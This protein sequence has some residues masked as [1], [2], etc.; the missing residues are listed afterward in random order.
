M[1]AVRL[2]VPVLVPSPYSVHLRI[3]S[4]ALIPPNPN[5]FDSAISKVWPIALLRHIIQLALR[6][7]IIEIDRRRQHLVDQ[8]QHGDARLKSAGAAEQVPGHRLR[9]ADLQLVAQRVLAEDELDGARLVAIARRRRRGMCID[10]VHI[11][12]L[13]SA[14]LGRRACCAVRPRLR[15]PCPSCGRRRRSYRSR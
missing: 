12:R 7:G 11:F 2:L 6:I 10:V 4:V 3:I 8:R 1:R 5:E 13:D 9:A 15:E 14:S